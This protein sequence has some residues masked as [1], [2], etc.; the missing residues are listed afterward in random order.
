MLDLDK[1]QAITDRINEGRRLIQE[2]MDEMTASGMEALSYR[3]GENEIHVYGEDSVKALPGYEITPRNCE[4]YPTEYSAVFNGIRLF[5][6]TREAFTADS[7]TEDCIEN[8]EHHYDDR[9]MN[10]NKYL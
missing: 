8:Y 7:D 2:A 6:V 9:D 10:D 4:T 3:Y 1:L 5:A